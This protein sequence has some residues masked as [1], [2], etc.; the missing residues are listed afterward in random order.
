VSGRLRV[1]MA[2]QAV[3]ERDPL[4]AFTVGWIRA[5]A[6]R[7]ARVHV[8]C[9]RIG[10]AALPPNVSVASLGGRQGASRLQR[11]AAL[12]RQAL[13]TLRE[14]DV[15]FAH[16]SPRLAC[17]G[18]VAAAMRRRP[19]VLWYV[20]RHISAELRLA[21]ALSAKVATATAGSFPLATPKVNV[22]GHGVDAAF[23]APASE[24]PAASERRIVMVGRLSEVKR[25]AALLEALPCILQ[26][27]PDAHVCF[28]GGS[29]EGEGSYRAGLETRAAQLGV[30]AHVSFAG[31]LT[32]ADVRGAYRSAAV[33]VN[34]SP[35]GLF[36][37][38]AL[39]SLMTGTPTIVSNP[40]FAPLFDG[41]PLSAC[42][43]DVEPGT[44]GRAVNAMLSLSWQER[45]ALMTPVR[46][47]TIARHALEP[48]M[49][50]LV[51]LLESVA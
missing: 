29:P 44:L 30:T 8:V 9:F 19:M 4:L 38:S 43:P 10:Q 7:V 2:T 48:F 45:K 36:D 16:M 49:D 27:H 18:G 46:Q 15:F 28:I 1:L 40:A 32:P 37:K 25:Q 22:L 20:H 34:V 3:D 41:F 47:R 35:P 11:L 6:A 23:F 5:M 17:W 26:A 39:E 50:R 21:T 12:E 14:A 42:V 33:A 24:E 31:A 51:A 13:T